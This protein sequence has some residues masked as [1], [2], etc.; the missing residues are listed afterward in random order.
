MKLP[1]DVVETA[2]QALGGKNPTAKRMK[3]ILADYMRLKSAKPGEVVPLSPGVTPQDVTTQETIQRLLEDV[4]KEDQ[5]S[6]VLGTDGE[7]VEWE[8][9]PELDDEERTNYDPVPPH[10]PIH[11]DPIINALFSELRSM[12]QEIQG[13]RKPPTEEEKEAALAA[14]KLPVPAAGEWAGPIG[15]TGSAS[16]PQGEWFRSPFGPPIQMKICNCSSCP[17]HRK[18]HYFCPICRTGP[19]DYNRVIGGIKNHLAPG[20]TWGIQHVMCSIPCWN[21]Y[22]PLIDGRPRPQVDPFAPVNP[23]VAPTA[24]VDLPAPRPGLGSD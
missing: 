24:T 7:T 14:G 2:K 1:A 23:N 8:K 18:V 22:Q 10:P 20:S 9:A 19:H 15:Y 12:R 17:P 5:P 13:L 4:P 3:D 11:P 16:L 21:Q 6:V